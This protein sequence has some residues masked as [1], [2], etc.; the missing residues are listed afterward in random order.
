M[1]L[2]IEIVGFVFTFLWIVVLADVIVSWVLD[3]L[4]PVRSFL[5]SIVQPMLAPIRRLIPSINGIDLSP[6]LLLIVLNIA[7]RL[8]VGLL[9]SAI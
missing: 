6:L 2:I 9:V 5:D 7:Q 1:G 3:P 4:H 8:I